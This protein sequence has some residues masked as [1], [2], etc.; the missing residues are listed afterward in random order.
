MN[1]YPPG[2][3]GE[4]QAQ[5]RDVWLAEASAAFA[6]TP[7]CGVNNTARF[8]GGAR[9][10]RVVYMSGTRLHR[11]GQYVVHSLQAQRGPEVVR[12]TSGIHSGAEGGRIDCVV[13]QR[14]DLKGLPRWED[15]HAVEVALERLEDGDALKGAPQSVR[16][17]LRGEEESERRGGE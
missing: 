6:L 10:Q 3:R 12:E 7:V 14:H 4:V 13:I 16:P 15:S 2:P 5:V 9:T 1:L 8:R 11:D 17:A